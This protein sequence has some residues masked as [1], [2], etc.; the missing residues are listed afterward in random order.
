MSLF[1]WLVGKRMEEGDHRQRRLAKIIREANYKHLKLMKCFFSIQRPLLTFNFQK[2]VIICVVSFHFFHHQFYRENKV[3]PW[4]KT[5]TENVNKPIL[6]ILVLRPFNW[7]L[8]NHIPARQQTDGSLHLLQYVFN[9][10]TVKLT[11]WHLK[12]QV[13]GSNSAIEN[14]V[15]GHCWLKIEIEQTLR[16]GN[17]RKQNEKVKW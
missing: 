12:G 17:E 4:I 13:C 11:K 5:L 10:F 9:M 3:K 2:W 15:D 7:K 16:R 1:N 8:V 6:S 14:S